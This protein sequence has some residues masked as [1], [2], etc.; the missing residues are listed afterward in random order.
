M[1]ILEKPREIAFRVLQQRE[2]SG[3]FIEDL[4]EN[5]S[6]NTALTPPDTRLLFELSYGV[7]RWQKTLDSLIENKTGGR[8]QSVPIQVLLRLG[9]YQLFWLN[10]IPDHAVVFETVAIAKRNGLARYSGFINAVLRGY[11]RERAT[12]TRLLEDLKTTNPPAGYSHPDWI[13]ERWKRRMGLEEASRLMAWNN[14]PARVFARLNTLRTDETALLEHWREEG[15]KCTAFTAPWLKAAAV[16]EIRP[17]H[18]IADLPSFRTGSFYLQDPSTLLAVQLL[19]PLPDENVLDCCA[20]PGG[21][22][23]LMAQLMKN[24]G[25]IVASDTHPKRLNLLKENCARLGA[26]CVIPS[27]GAAEIGKIELFDRILVDAPCSNTGV[28]RRRVDLRW[29]IADTELKRL[30]NAQLNLLTEAAS[31]LKLEGTLVYSTCSLESEENADII[32]EFLEQS[33]GFAC[34]AQM[35]LIPTTDGVDGCYAARIRRTAPPK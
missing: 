30:K 13:Y 24:Q 27:L 34:D 17:P 32:A 4:V 25:R 35:A 1:L 8:R 10:R 11:I 15:V 28:M 7:V 9:L 26:T 31:K 33:R 3:I 21:K 29:R 23:S 6:G 18:R 22:T 2:T 5:E 12:T 20:A 19:D 16:F 14:T